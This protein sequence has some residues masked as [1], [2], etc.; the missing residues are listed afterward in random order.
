MLIRNTLT[1]YLRFCMLMHDG[2]GSTTLQD[3]A[4][5][6]LSQ[7]AL[8]VALNLWDL[9]EPTG[10][11]TTLQQV[12]SISHS[13]HHNLPRASEPKNLAASLAGVN[14]LSEV[15]LRPGPH[16]RGI[17]PHRPASCARR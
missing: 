16:H 5:R 6:T 14:P 4:D 12:I 15:P 17:R 9:P 3:Y 10:N 11:Y 7:A 1:V 8:P 2:T 13:Y